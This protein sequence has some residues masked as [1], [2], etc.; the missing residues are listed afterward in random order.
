MAIW[1]VKGS[2]YVAM[3]RWWPHSLFL[4]SIVTQQ[5]TFPALANINIVPRADNHSLSLSHTHTHACTHTHA[6][7]HT[8]WFLWLTGTLHWRNGCYTVQTLFFYALHLNLPLTGNF[9]NFTFSKKTHSVGFLSLLNYG[10]TEKVFINHLLL[11]IPV[12][13]M[14]LYKFVSS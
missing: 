12:I 9:C 7:T 3:W 6:R 1:T 4:F 8:R 11:V 13:P 5:N 2:V 14:S 10:V